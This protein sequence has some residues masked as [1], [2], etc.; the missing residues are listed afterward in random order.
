M[1]IL[2]KFM[3]DF[4]IL[5]TTVLFISYFSSHSINNKCRLLYAQSVSSKQLSVHFELILLLL[6]IRPGQDELKST[7]ETFR[8]LF[9]SFH[10]MVRLW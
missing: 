4:E 6:S 5:F 7:V 9:F 1:R 10:P 2:L 8:L 3:S